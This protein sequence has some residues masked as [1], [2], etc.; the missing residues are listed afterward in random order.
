[1]AYGKNYL[2]FLAS[3]KYSAMEDVEYLSNKM[4]NHLLLSAEF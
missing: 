4:F 2:I 1:M 3:R